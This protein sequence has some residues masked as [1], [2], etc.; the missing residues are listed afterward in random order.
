[1]LIRTN[2]KL[3]QNKYPIRKHVNE[4]TPIDVLYNS[5]LLSPK[6]LYYYNLS[7]QTLRPNDIENK[8]H[9]K[10]MS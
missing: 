6:Y 1:M 3:I 7:L 4:K 9:Y 2:L 8:Q 5:A 10:T